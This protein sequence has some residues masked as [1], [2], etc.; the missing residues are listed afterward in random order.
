MRSMPLASTLSHHPFDGQE[1]AITP[2]FECGVQ[3]KLGKKYFQKLWSFGV[4]KPFLSTVAYEITARRIKY[5]EERAPL[6]TTPNPVHLQL[7]TTSHI[8]RRGDVRNGC[9]MPVV[10][11]SSVEWDG[12]IRSKNIDRFFSSQQVVIDNIIFVRRG[13]FLC[14][15]LSAGV[16]QCVCF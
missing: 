9:D 7:P 13:S 10:W 11:K 14:F 8:A 12:W 6:S 1:E 16:Q 15:T 4:S 5:N 2:K 3:E